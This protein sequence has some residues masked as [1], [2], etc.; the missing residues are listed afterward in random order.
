MAKLAADGT[1]GCIYSLELEAAPLEDSSIG[2]V[3]QIIAL[4][5]SLFVHVEAVGILHYKLTAAHKTEPGA[6]LV[7]ELGLDLI[8]IPWELPVRFKVTAHH[9]SNDLFVCRP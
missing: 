2:I 1:G 3:H 7:P 6:H 4:Y 8:D 5:G 9:I